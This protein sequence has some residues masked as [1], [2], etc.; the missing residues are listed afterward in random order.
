MRLKVMQGIRTA[1]TVLAILSLSAPAIAQRGQR[2][3]GGGAAASAANAPGEGRGQAGPRLKIERD[4]EYAIA[5]GQALTLDLYR[6]DPVT[7]PDAS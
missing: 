1:L 3:A 5:G 7:A 2:G 6:L 4:L